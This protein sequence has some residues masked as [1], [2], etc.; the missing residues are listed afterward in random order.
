VTDPALE[1]CVGAGRTSA[2][3]GE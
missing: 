2:P 1:I 3:G